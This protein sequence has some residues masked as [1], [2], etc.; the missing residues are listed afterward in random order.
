M[1]RT[2][3]ESVNMQVFSMVQKGQENMQTII[4]IIRKAFAFILFFQVVSFCSGDNKRKVLVKQC[5]STFIL[6]VTKYNIVFAL[7]FFVGAEVISCRSFVG[8]LQK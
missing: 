4:I 5:F 1:K 2:I 6:T 7:L 8:A 3:I